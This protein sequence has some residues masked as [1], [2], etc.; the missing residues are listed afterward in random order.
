VAAAIDTLMPAANARGIKVQTLL[1]PAAGLV[2][3]DTDR[4]RQIVWNLIS[5]AIKFTDKGGR[6]TVRVERVDPNVVI[7]V[8]DSGVGISPQVLPHVFE[9]FRQ[10]DSSNTR[11]H[12]GLGLGLAVVRHLVELH[13]GQVTASSAGEGR[14]AT[15]TVT[16]PLLDPADSADAASGNGGEGAAPA[17]DELPEDSPRLDGVR[18]LVVDRS[19]EVREVIARILRLSGA[20][21]EAV[22]SAADALAAFAGTVPDVLLSAIDMEGETGYSLLRKV[23]SLPRDVGGAV[24]AAA[25]TAYSRTEDRVRALRAGFQMYMTKPVQ[26]AELLAVVAALADLRR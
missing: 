24:P 14:G 18:V 21:V 7:T 20:E 8:E 25:L 10:G 19:E 2:S 12:G 15:F 22:G 6:V 5:N 4:L 1:D 16:L 23:R 11:N 9:R 3:G 13:G 17:T 26:P